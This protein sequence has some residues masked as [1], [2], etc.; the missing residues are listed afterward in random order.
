MKFFHWLA[1]KAGYEL[2]PLQTELEKK[3]YHA[4]IDRGMP[5]DRLHLGEPLDDLGMFHRVACARWVGS[6]RWGL[7]ILWNN[8]LAPITAR[9]VTEAIVQLWD[10]FTEITPHVM[11]SQ[12]CWW[13][14]DDGG[15]TKGE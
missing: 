2:L 3:V 1:K 13:I 7:G 12:E 14:M 9:K 15:L 8:Q 5:I 10:Q 4:L 11:W 6:K